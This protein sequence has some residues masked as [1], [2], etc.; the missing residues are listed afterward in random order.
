MLR[1][2]HCGG[3]VGV[4]V[5]SSVR[6]PWSTWGFDAIGYA[7]QCTRCRIT[8]PSFMSKE[9]AI[10]RWEGADADGAVALSE[11]LGRD[12]D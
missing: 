7:V 5:T 3:K 4:V 10:A 1:C 9:A 8:T 2:Q 12:S 6:D 11:E